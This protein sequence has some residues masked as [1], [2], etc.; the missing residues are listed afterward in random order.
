M[1]EKQVYNPV[2]QQKDDHQLNNFN[3]YA[4]EVRLS[5]QNK[6]ILQR[7][8]DH[9][10]IPNQQGQYMPVV[11]QE[12]Q[13]EAHGHVEMQ[14]VNPQVHIVNIQ[15]QPQPQPQVHIVNMQQPQ[16]PQVHGKLCPYCKFVN[17]IHA[18]QCQMCQISFVQSNQ[19]THQFHQTHQTHQTT[20]IGLMAPHPQQHQQTMTNQQ[21]NPNVNAVIVQNVNFNPTPIHV[22]D[23]P[24]CMCLKYFKIR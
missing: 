3:P 16:P 19:Q 20:P 17:N 4:S 21:R 11:Q 24:T 22:D 23:D 18:T 2:P 8:T 14:H 10:R 13:H 12:Q 7:Q 5:I 15:Q 6:F 1:A 9:Q